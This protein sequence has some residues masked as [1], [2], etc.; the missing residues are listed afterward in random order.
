MAKIHGVIT[1]NFLNIMS[2]KSFEEWSPDETSVDGTI[3]GLCANY[4]SA[5]SI[6]GVLSG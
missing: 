1:P 3:R 5:I 6:G 2:Q 4:R